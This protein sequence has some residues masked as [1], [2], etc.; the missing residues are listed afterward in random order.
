MSNSSS[1]RPSTT[2]AAGTTECNIRDLLFL[3]LAM[4]A[5]DQSVETK[6]DAALSPVPGP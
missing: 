6:C 5:G 3:A 1:V 4:D 2:R